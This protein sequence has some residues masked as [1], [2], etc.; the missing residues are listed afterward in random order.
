MGDMDGQEATAAGWGL[1]QSG[2]ASQKLRFVDIKVE[3]RSFVA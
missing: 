3:H 1:T 2:E